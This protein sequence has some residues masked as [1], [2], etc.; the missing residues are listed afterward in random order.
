MDFVG[1]YSLE[2]H[3]NRAAAATNAL[4]FTYTAA[5]NL[6]EGR[7]YFPTLSTSLV[8]AVVD[9]DVKHS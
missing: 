1:S 3:I 5:S 8:Q 7:N 2:T 9:R 6:S 4:I